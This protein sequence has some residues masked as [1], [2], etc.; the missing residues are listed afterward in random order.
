V[1]D[2]LTPE[3]A[4]EMLAA[5]GQEV[6][7]FT[8]ATLAAWERDRARLATV[9]AERDHARRLL[10][11]L[12]VAL[13][14]SRLYDPSML[15]G[16]AAHLV[17]RLAT[18]TAQRDALVPLFEAVEWARLDDDQADAVLDAVR[19]IRAERATTGATDADA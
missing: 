7:D 2:D 5:D 9:T 14:G 3:R 17:A 13:N 15:A 10:D 4:R 1:T 11:D 12:S 8:D 18:V 16:K 6:T 19:A